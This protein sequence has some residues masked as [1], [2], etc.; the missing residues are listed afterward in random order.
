MPTLVRLQPEPAPRGDSLPRAVVFDLDGTLVD[1][2]DDISRLLNIVLGEDGVATFSGHEVRS[3]MGEG[4]RA[5]IAKALRARGVPGRDDRIEQLKDR[6]LDLYCGRPVALTTAFPFVA[7]VLGQLAGQGVSV[8]ICTN[9][10]KRPAQLILE[11]L[12]LDRHVGA[13]VG[14]DSG[15]GQKP[16]P[17][18]LLACASM[19]GVPASTVVYVGDHH[20]D[21]ETARAARVPVVAVAFGYSGVPAGDLGADR[22]ISCL[23]ELPAAIRGLV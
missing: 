17:A 23:S 8:G 19:L 15:F 16:D 22:T 18:P 11:A 9:K 12:G 7:E 13:V 20:I 10:A 4:V 1:S 21:V 3:L 2:V 6:F 14:A 5:L